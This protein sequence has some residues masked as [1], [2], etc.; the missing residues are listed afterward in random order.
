M[1]KASSYDPQEARLNKM[2]GILRREYG[3]S[4]QT[5]NTVIDI[6][7]WSEETM[8]AI[9]YSVAGENEFEDLDD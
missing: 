5:L 4:S 8:K 7:G 3:V 2:Y 1:I 9:L 6:N